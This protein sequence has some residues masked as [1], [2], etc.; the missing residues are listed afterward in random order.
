MHSSRNVGPEL[1]RYGSPIRGAGSRLIFLTDHLTDICLLRRDQREAGNSE[2]RETVASEDEGASLASSLAPR[3][4]PQHQVGQITMNK[5]RPHQLN[6]CG[7]LFFSV[8]DD[9]PVESVETV[10]L[11]G[12]SQIR[13]RRKSTGL[14]DSSVQKTVPGLDPG[15]AS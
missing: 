15:S 14:K 3:Y 10:L 9:D 4:A 13:D 7:P 6:V 8:I 5:V 11:P 1:G 2:I 12:L